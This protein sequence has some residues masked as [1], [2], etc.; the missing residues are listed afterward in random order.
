MF[1]IYINEL[2]AELAKYGITVKAFADDVKMYLQ[3]TDNLD[4]QKLQLAVDVLCRW[5]NNRQLS[6]SVNRPKCCILNIGKCVMLLLASMVL[7]YL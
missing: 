3:I 6:I 7:L 1:L 5:A 2:I 4:V